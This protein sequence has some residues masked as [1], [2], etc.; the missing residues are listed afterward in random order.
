VATQTAPRHWWDEPDEVIVTAMD[1]L[2][3]QAR[4][5]E[6]STPKPRRKR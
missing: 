3:V 4:Q 1:V 6:E 5:L 2:A